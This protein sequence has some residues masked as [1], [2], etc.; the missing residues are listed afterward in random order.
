VSPYLD[1]VSLNTLSENSGSKF[2]TWT[3]LLPIT[4]VYSNYRYLA[5]LMTK[6]HLPLCRA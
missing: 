2:A 5:S 6:F 1:I 3:L 4:A